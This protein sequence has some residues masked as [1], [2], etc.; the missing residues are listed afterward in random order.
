[1]AKPAKTP[2]PPPNTAG[3]YCRMSRDAEGDGEGIARQEEVC[4]SLAERLNVDV[5]KVY[6]D[7]DIGASEQTSKKKVRYDYRC[8]RTITLVT[9]RTSSRIPA[10][11]SRAAYPNCRTST[12]S[13]GPQVCSST[14]LRPV[15]SIYPRRT[16]S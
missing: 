9:L 2:T 12:T 8:W 15:T 14:R 7:N 16:V 4:R 6:A 11:D 13:T 5:V 1:M 10:P 3:I